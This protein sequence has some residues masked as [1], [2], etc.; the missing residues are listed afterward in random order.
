MKIQISIEF[1]TDTKQLGVFAPLATLE[2]RESTAK[3]FANAISVALNH[4]PP[5]IVPPPPGFDPALSRNGN[6]PFSQA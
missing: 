3:L 4:R 1:D 2:E 5:K 6:P